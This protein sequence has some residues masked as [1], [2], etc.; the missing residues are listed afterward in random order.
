MK[1]VNLKQ[2]VKII[3]L[4]IGAAILINGIALFFCIKP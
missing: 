4:I 3:F 2:I 1:T